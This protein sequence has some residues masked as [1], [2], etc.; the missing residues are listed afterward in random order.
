MAQKTRAA[1]KDIQTGKEWQKLIT[2]YRAL[3]AGRTPENFK[4][5]ARFEPAPNS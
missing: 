2:L 5:L 4:K 3:A 1:L